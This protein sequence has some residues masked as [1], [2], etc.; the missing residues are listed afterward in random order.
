MKI[1][2][3]VLIIT[4]LFS[5]PLNSEQPKNTWDLRA[6]STGSG[7]VNLNY[8]DGRTYAVI[9]RS[10]AKKIVEI[11]DKISIHSGIYPQIFLNESNAIN[12]FAGPINGVPTVWINK[13]MFDIFVKDLGIAAHI[14]GHEMGHLYFD[15]SGNRRSVTPVFNI[16]ANIA[17]NILQTTITKKYGVPQIIS[18]EIGRE[19]KD[20]TSKV[21]TTAYTRDNEREADRIGLEWAIKN[22]YDPYGAV[23]GFEMLNEI[24]KRNPNLPPAFLQSH[25]IPQ[26]RIENAKVQIA[27]YLGN[28]NSSSQEKAKNNIDLRRLEVKEVVKI[29]DDI[30]R[31]NAL[32]DE[33][34]QNQFPRSET[35]KNGMMAFAKKDYVNAK[36]NFEKCAA[37]GDAS[38]LNNLG[39]IYQFGLSVPRDV[40]KSA[41]YYKQSSDKGLSI[42]MSNYA[43]SLIRGDEGI[44]NNIQGLNLI[45]S[46]A[47]KGSPTAMG[48]T[49]YISQIRG[50]ENAKNLNLPSKDILVNYAKVSSM[51][52]VPE[53]HL[54]MGSFYR[55]GFGVNQNFDL[56][57]N[58]LLLASNTKKNAIGDLYLLYLEEKPD[59]NKARIFREKIINEKN[60]QASAIV[61]N[62][63]C[64][65]DT[66]EATFSLLSNALSKTLSNEQIDSAKECYIW[67]KVGASGG[68]ISS[69]RR[70]GVLLYQ[71]YGVEKDKIEGM[72]WIL[73][74]SKRGYE[75]AKKIFEKYKNDFSSEELNKIE[76]RTKEILN[77]VVKS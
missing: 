50:I 23:R 32:I 7:S 54:A 25:P 74:S 19:A 73:S 77:Q 68:S 15:H 56:A 72:A 40:K 66:A 61:S 1:L 18:Q 28:S 30:T 60:T 37:E 48:M 44:V 2:L 49:A 14:L 20:F 52:G 13:P 29:T 59:P 17:G 6:I 9:Q 67:T 64:P 8:P 33:E 11:L 26:E 71:G 35:G 4:L 65:V 12:A 34:K 46:A 47:E 5:S 62:K 21:V 3:R 27:S 53:G 36:I 38:C 31:L 75:P 55:K 10:D 63:Y 45:I 76:Q 39:V 58:N 70:Y 24:H 16:V 69:A 22:G 43:Y 51:R 42:G 41:E 57:E